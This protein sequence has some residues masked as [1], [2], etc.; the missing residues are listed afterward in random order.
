LLLSLWSCGRRASG[1][2]FCTGSDFDIV[3]A[4]SIPFL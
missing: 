4:I 1:R 2:P 3:L